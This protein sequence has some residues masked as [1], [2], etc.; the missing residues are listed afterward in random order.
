MKVKLD[1]QRY[2]KSDFLRHPAGVLLAV[3]RFH[4]RAGNN[5][6][7]ACSNHASA[8][9]FQCGWFSAADR[10]SAGAYLATWGPRVFPAYFQEPLH[11]FFH[12][13]LPLDCDSRMRSISSMFSD[14]QGSMLAI[15]R[16]QAG[17]KARNDTS[18]VNGP[19]AIPNAA[20]DSSQ[21]LKVTRQMPLYGQCSAV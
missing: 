10:L 15:S 11:G 16:A 2:E 14:L 12:G 18:G 20:N 7:Q 3:H 19:P 13:L 6:A 1:W 8:K 5:V 17:H 9:T 4:Q 21:T